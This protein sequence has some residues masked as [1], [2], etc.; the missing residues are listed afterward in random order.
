MDS[1]NASPSS[2][3]AIGARF[4]SAVQQPLDRGRR[5]LQENRLGDGIRSLSRG[6]LSEALQRAIEAAAQAA[7]TAPP[8]IEGLLPR[9]EIDAVLEAIDESQQRV[10]LVVRRQDN[11]VVHFAVPKDVQSVTLREQLHEV[12]S[13][14]ARDKDISGA[15]LALAEDIARWSSLMERISAG[16]DSD[17]QLLAF[18]RRRKTLRAAARIGAV[19]ALLAIASV[20]A[21]SYHVNVTQ[22]AREEALLAAERE[23]SAR[24]AA[25]FKAALAQADPCA[26]DEL[27][28]EDHARLTSAQQQRLT[29]R[30]KT[31]TALEARRAQEQRCALLAAH[32]QSAQLTADDRALAADGAA[33]LDRIATKSLQPADLLIDDASLPCATA[34]ASAALWAAF[35]RAAG[36]TTPTT[37]GVLDGISP[38][39]S[40]VLTAHA[41]DLPPAVR[42]PL[43]HRAETVASMAAPTG[44]GDPITA[45]AMCALKVSLGIPPADACVK[46]G[47][48]K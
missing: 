43:G 42:T 25:R 31:C 9:A 22:R 38:K 1:P 20:T 17:P 15:L 30:V 13:N 39:V 45:R 26:P 6:S 46:L 4:S 21:W 32:L 16:L 23:A 7:S 28:P 10:M 8:V 47:V 44:K 27:Q 40:T 41:S 34:P 24:S 18:Q 19:A 37:W 33:L 12:A 48:S 35:A 36:A 3:G 14:F 29:E 2:S 11:T 5:Y